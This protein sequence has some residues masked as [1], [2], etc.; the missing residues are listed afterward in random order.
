M[1]KKKFLIKD[2]N[3]FESIS[4][5]NNIGLSFWLCH[6]SLLGIARDRKL[7][8]WEHDIDI[9]TWN[10]VDKRKI[11]QAFKKKDFTVLFK[12]FENNSIITFKKKNFRDIDINFY[13]VSKN[14]KHVYQR[15]YAMR[16][17][18][19]R[20]IYVLSVSKSYKGRYKNLVTLFSLFQ[21]LFLYIKKILEK[22]KL[23]YVPAGFKTKIY[24]FKKFKK[25]NYYGSEI[26]IPYDYKNYLNDLYG[27]NWK[28]PNPNYYWE[29]NKNIFFIKKG[30]H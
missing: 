14:R 19:I 4:I 10:N 11:I 6:G 3:F 9:G 5:L 13:E 28:I 22:K 7:I 20:L 27:K 8:K 18:F 29:K 15:H 17:I 30:S 26:N 2:P 16:N 12:K 21:P 24:Y 1:S 25:V 23:F